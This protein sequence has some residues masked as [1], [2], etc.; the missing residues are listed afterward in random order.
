MCVSHVCVCVC[1]CVCDMGTMK[2]SIPVYG[3]TS[4]SHEA[5]DTRNGIYISKQSLTNPFNCDNMH[6]NAVVCVD[7]LY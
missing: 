3:V 6:Y 2:S 5:T 4:M 7:V 1:V